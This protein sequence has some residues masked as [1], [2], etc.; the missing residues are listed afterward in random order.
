[1]AFDAKQNEYPGF[2]CRAVRSDFRFQCA[3]ASRG[4]IWVS[5]SGVA[6]TA[7]W[8]ILMRTGYVAT[9]WQGFTA[10]VHFCVRIQIKMTLARG[11]KGLPPGGV[12]CKLL[13]FEP[14][15]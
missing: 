3:S 14:R 12:A 15:Y 7:N 1:M 6:K 9:V 5:D 8:Q 13:T 10:K 11:G 2:G 4:T